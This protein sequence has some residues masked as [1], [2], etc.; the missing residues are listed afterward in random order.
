MGEAAEGGKLRVRN[1][2]GV[3]QLRPSASRCIGGEVRQP[4]LGLTGRA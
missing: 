3:G 4:A 1:E 2:K